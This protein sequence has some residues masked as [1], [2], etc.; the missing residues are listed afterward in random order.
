MEEIQEGSTNDSIFKRD[1]VFAHLNY[2]LDSGHFKLIATKSRM[3]HGELQPLVEVV[4]SDVRWMSRVCPRD[5]TWQSNMSL[6]SVLVEDKMSEGNVFKHL[7]SA[8]P[9]LT[10]SDV[11][12]TLSESVFEMEFE[13]M[14]KSSKIGYSIKMRTQPVQI[15]YNPATIE[16]ISDFFKRQVSAKKA[17]LHAIEQ[18]ILDA[19]WARYEELKSQT[20]TGLYH[21][22]D[23]LLLGQVKVRLDLDPRFVYND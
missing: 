3:S 18:Q 10:S 15:V 21:A 17:D 16:R 19:A 4:F 1:T 6:R 12:D 11:L 14:P 22:M 13:K 20:K 5:S 7:V 2:H 9:K 23:D 8:Q